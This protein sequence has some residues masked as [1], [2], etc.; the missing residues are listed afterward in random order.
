MA[1]TGLI[2]A[3][4]T[5]A[6][7]LLGGGQLEKQKQLTAAQEESAK[8][9]AE[10]QQ[11]LAL[12]MWDK[13]NVKGQVKAMKEAG[14][15][16][17][18]M[19]GGSGAGGQMGPSMAMPQGGQ[20]A[21]D[22]A[23]QQAAV[24]NGL[25]VAN[26]DLI[27]AQTQKTEAEANKIAGIDTEEA[28]GR[29]NA[30][31]FQNELNNAIGIEK[32]WKNYLYQSDKLGAESDRANAEWNL[33]KKHGMLENSE[34]ADSPAAKAVR[35]GF[36]KTV[37]DLENAKKDGRVKDAEATIKEFTANLTKQ[38]LGEGTPWYVK[39]LGDLLTKAGLN[40]MNTAADTLRK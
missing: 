14:M 1:I 9:L 32:M 6:L 8:R 26:L 11:G 22:V 37:Q 38:G 16:P 18:A 28:T 17:A 29:V 33:F 2:P 40:P 20:A 10:Y 36:E 4:A 25:A 23:K 27:K 7:G 31:K 5:A 12:S 39:I 34:N 19:Y 21:T 13:T 15:N 24:Q 35:A 30:Q 3:A